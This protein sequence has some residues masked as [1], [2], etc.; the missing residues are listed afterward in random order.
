LDSGV[1]DQVSVSKFLQLIFLPVRTVLLLSVVL[2]FSVILHQF[3]TTPNGDSIQD[4]FDQTNGIAQIEYDGSLLTNTTVNTFTD[5][6]AEILVILM[7][8]FLM[9][10]VVKQS[11]P[12]STPLVGKWA[13]SAFG[14]VQ[15]SMLA[16]PIIP[17]PGSR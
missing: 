16:V 14:L 3:A 7:V 15:K 1:G 11:I 12:S 4:R 13:E 6:F 5:G 2:I 10:I 8:L 17:I 9:W